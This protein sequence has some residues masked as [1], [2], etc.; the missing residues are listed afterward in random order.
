[1]KVICVKEE[2]IQS[3]LKLVMKDQLRRKFEN[4]QHQ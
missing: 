2:V 3:A 4:V 1:M